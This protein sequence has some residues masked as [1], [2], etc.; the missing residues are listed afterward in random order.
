[1]LLCFCV[2]VSSPTRTLAR[3]R[4]YLDMFEKEPS[5]QAWERGVKI[6]TL[7]QMADNGFAA[8]EL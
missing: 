1:M 2:L 6:L 3:R 8:V 4:A 7:G 5:L